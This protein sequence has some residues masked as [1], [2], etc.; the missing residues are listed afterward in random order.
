MKN[1]LTHPHL[2]FKY[3]EKRKGFSNIS[4][5]CIIKYMLLLH[6]FPPKTINKVGIN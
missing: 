6:Y 4:Y 5:N 2:N 1:V 3:L